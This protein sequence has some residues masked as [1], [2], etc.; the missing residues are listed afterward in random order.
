MIE[1]NI[2]EKTLQYIDVKTT[3]QSSLLT[4]TKFF[5]KILNGYEFRVSNPI[6][7]ESHV[8]SICKELTYLYKHPWERSYIGIAPGYGKSTLMSYFMAW[9]LTKAPHSNFIYASCDKDLAIKHNSVVKMII[10]TREYRELFGIWIDSNTRGK[11]YFKIN[12]GGECAAFSMGGGIV[13][14]NAGLPGMLEFS[15]G[16]IIDDAHKPKDARSDTKRLEPILTYKDTLLQRVRGINV[17]V[18]LIAQRLHQDDLP[19][20]V[21]NAAN[22][23]K[24]GDGRKWRTLILP[25]LD[26]AGNALDPVKETKEML[27]AEK[28]YNPLVFYAQKQQNPLPPGGGLYKREWFVE[29]AQEPEI[30]QSIITIDTAET[31]KTFNDASVMTFSGVYKISDDVYGLHVIDCWEVRVEP[32]ELESIVRSF[33]HTCGLHKVQPS[34]IYIE[35]KSTGVSLLSM[36]KQE[37]G[38]NVMEIKRTA[39]SGSKMDRFIDIQPFIGKRLL[40]L[41]KGDPCAQLVIDHMCKI[42]DNES[43]SFDDIC[44]T[45][46]DAIMYTIADKNFIKSLD[47]RSNAKM[48]SI[49]AQNAANR[50]RQYR[51][52]YGA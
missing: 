10:E 17:F 23:P 9:C 48:N 14:R 39:S 12:K 15:G 42:T 5:F 28:E 1:R 11:S 44:D 2:D 41:K 22:D 32:F 25:C 51:S 30:I 21:M 43:H 7:R 46:C 45:I 4:F 16:L 36:L 52:L 50:Q 26:S 33:I 19:S 13:G 31:E 37:Q 3:L 27:L 34:T 18:G 24:S 35:K 6:G 47:K 38:L 8:I 29:H 20:F 49:I 40:S